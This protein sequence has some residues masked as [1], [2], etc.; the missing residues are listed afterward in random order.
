[1]RN[2]HY[3]DLKIAQHPAKLDSFVRGEITA[4]LYVRVKP[5]NLC[6]HACSWCIYKSDR[7][8]T[9]RGEQHMASVPTSMHT[10]MKEADIIPTAKMLEVLDDFK[11]M[12]VKAITFSG[13]VSEF[14]YGYETSNFGD[15]G[16]ALAAVATPGS[17]KHAAANVMTQTAKLAAPN[18]LWYPAMYRFG[19]CG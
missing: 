17:A 14:V 8:P 6:N 2:N 4:P 11:A 1:M 5:I 9:S 18:H 13:G 12:G 7:K 16:A 15:L 19:M 10:D 3:S